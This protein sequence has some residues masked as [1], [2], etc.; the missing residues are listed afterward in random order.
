MARSRRPAAVV[1]RGG[2]QFLG[3]QRHRAHARLCR[4]LR[5]PDLPGKP[6]FGG[7]ILSHD[8]F[9]SALL[10]RRGWA[11]HGDDR[12][13][14]RRVSAHDRRSRAARSA[15]DAGQPA[16]LALLGASGLAATS[17]LHLLIGASAYLT[18]PGWLLLLA[19]IAQVA[20]ARVG[21]G[22]EG[23]ALTTVPGGVLALTVLLLFGPKLMG[24]IWILADGQRCAAF[25]G[26]W[27]ALRSV[28]AELVLSTLFAPVSMVLQ[29]KAL[30]GCCSA[31]LAMERA[32]PR[33]PGDRLARN[34]AGH[35]RTY[36]AGPGLCRHGLARS[37]HGL[38]AFADNA[39]LLTAP[40]L[41]SQTSRED[42]GEAAGRRGLF[43]VPAR[44]MRV[45]RAEVPRSRRRA[46]ARRSGGRG[47][48]GARPARF[49]SPHC[50]KT[51]IASYAGS[52]F[53]AV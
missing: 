37:G 13:Q 31:F 21:G 10:R 6:P 52:C 12:R 5:L 38:V 15:L 36:P 25:G 49:S 47:C 7:H 39:G 30:L 28:L 46:I 8:M 34:P 33:C 3:P 29:I 14:L 32:E 44:T 41:V 42:L 43:R 16:T 11:V 22:V 9:E 18:S 4:K 40:W 24:L 2:G 50:A 19:T 45:G 48:A 53:P 27:R 17:R 26:P 51:R 23:N 1:E 20:M 35:A